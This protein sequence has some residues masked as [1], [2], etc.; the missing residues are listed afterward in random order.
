M[1]RKPERQAVDLARWIPWD[2]AWKQGQRA[3]GQG[4]GSLDLVAAQLSETLAA[5]KI[6]AINCVV[7]ADRKVKM[8][9]LPSEIWSNIEI[10]V[11]LRGTGT[12]HERVVGWSPNDGCKLPEGRAHNIFL[13]R[14]AVTSMWPTDPAASAT[15]Q[16]RKSRP[17]GRPPGPPAINDWPMLLGA[18]IIMRVNARDNVTR[19]DS[20]L[21]DEFCE[22]CSEN[23]D[24]WQ[25]DQ[26]A[27]RAK[28]P[29]FLKLIR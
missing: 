14:A 10:R 22:Y 28:I 23:F 26:S 18:Y 11:V 29:A 13:D 5:G 16:G 21:A 25:P 19:N 17:G 6:P 27:V 7:T 1:A 8:I 4:V 12:S 15:P 9:R 24:G 20:E 3:V 2:D